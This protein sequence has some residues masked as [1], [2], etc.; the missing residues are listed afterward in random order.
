[1]QFLK[2]FLSEESGEMSAQYNYFVF[3]GLVTTFIATAFSSYT[4]KLAIVFSN[5]IGSLAH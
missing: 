1:M 5:A 2:R 3:G 4:G